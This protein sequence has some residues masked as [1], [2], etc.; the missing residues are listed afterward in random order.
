MSQNVRCPECGTVLRVPDS[1]AGA[2]F[3]CPKCSK[4]LRLGRA[5]APAAPLP[6]AA[7][8]SAQPASAIP[9]GSAPAGA[10]RAAAA[11]ASPLAAAASD[12]PPLRP[13]LVRWAIGLGS[14]A[15]LLVVLGL[16]GL[17][18]EPLAIAATIVM[19]VAMVA[20]LFVG[21]VWMTIAAARQHVMLGVAV[22]FVPMVGLVLAIIQR[23]RIVRGALVYV[24]CVLPAILCVAFLAAYQ[25]RYTAEGRTAARTAK[26]DE[27]RPDLEAMIRRTE[28]GVAAGAP[29]ATARFRYIQRGPEA[30]ITVAEAEAILSPFEHYV[31]GSFRIDE[32]AR[33]VEFDYHGPPRLAAQ[34]RLMLYNRTQTM[35]MEFPER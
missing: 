31:D 20:C 1:P 2:L 12:A 16:G 27:D 11:S 35:L 21:L 33:T 26:L 22:F 25:S 32:Q 5:S 18:A 23:G 9:P 10:R 17:F 7:S 29:L 6:S 19:I 14:A 13:F 24:S 15:A 3:R 34:Y 30:P 8:S 28:S 4:S